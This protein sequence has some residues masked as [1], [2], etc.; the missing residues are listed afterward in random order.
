MFIFGNV[1]QLILID[2]KMTLVYSSQDHRDKSRQH[3]NVGLIQKRN[4]HSSGYIR[5]IYL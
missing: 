5:N 2:N 1:S 3:Q 4:N